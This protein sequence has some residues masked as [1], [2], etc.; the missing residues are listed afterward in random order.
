[1]DGFAAPR[2]GV[3]NFSESG[4][5]ATGGD[6]LGGWPP[7]D[8]LDGWPPADDDQ[9]GGWPLATGVGRPLDAEGV[10]ISGVLGGTDDPDGY[11]DDFTSR[12]RHFGRLSREF[13]ARAT[14][15]VEGAAPQDADA[16]ESST[17]ESSAGEDTSDD[18]A[19]AE[20]EEVAGQDVGENEDGTLDSGP[21]HADSEP[22]SPA[23][24]LGFVV[25]L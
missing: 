4:P 3:P 9:P 22:G 5:V 21:R 20:D 17:D 7:A 19:A 18:D 13:R 14:G 11:F 1:M 25:D 6:D 12:L 10:A 24:L 16:G 2:G 8:D 15:G 23:P